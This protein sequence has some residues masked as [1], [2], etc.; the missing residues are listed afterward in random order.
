MFDATES[1]PFLLRF[2]QMIVL[3]S[4]KDEKI[5][6]SLRRNHHIVHKGKE[7]ADAFADQ[8]L[9]AEPRQEGPRRSKQ[10]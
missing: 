3:Q 5:E 1:T 7:E 9:V 4:Y 2:A 10:G 8:Q 6:N